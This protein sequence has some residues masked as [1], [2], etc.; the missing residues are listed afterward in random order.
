[1]EQL[2]EIM[3]ALERDQERQAERDKQKDAMKRLISA[4]ILSN[5][6]KQVKAKTFLPKLSTIATTGTTATKGP[7][8][9][10]MIRCL[11]TL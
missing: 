4:A 8:S 5:P 1:M 3:N 11:H 10:A 6:N 2:S 9:Q 7:R